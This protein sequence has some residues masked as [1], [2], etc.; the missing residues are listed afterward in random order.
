MAQGFWF[1]QDLSFLHLEITFPFAELCYTFEEKLFFSA[2]IILWK[3]VSKNQP[4]NIP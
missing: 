1:F 4:E 3:K 2:I